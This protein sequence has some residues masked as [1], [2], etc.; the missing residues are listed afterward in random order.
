MARNLPALFFQCGKI[1]CKTTIL[2]INAAVRRIRQRVRPGRS[3]PRIRKAAFRG[4]IVPKYT[5]D[6][7]RRR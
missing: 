4:F 1:F 6:R 3:Y 2:K 7:V 5:G